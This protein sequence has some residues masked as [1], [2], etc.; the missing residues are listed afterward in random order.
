MAIHRRPQ[1]ARH[2]LPRWLTRLITMALA[3]TLTLGLAAGLQGLQAPL[4]AAPAPGPAARAT[5]LPAEAIVVDMR[6]ANIYGFSTNDKSY[7][8]EGKLWLTYSAQLEQQLRQK[9]IDPI[10]LVSFYNKIKPWDS[11]LISLNQTPEILS[12]GR[13]RSSYTFN[14]NFYADDVDFKL[15][16]FGGLDLS[17]I[18]Q[19]ESTPLST[20]DKQQPIQ[21]IAG[22]GELGSRVNINGYELSGWQF[23]PIQRA[24][25][26]RLEQSRSL[27]PSRLEFQVAYQTSFWA[28]LV[29]WIL[30]LIIV[31][32]LTLFA[33]NI[34]GAM[35][36]ERLAIPPV[37][38]LTIVLMQQSYRDSLPSLPYLTFLDGLYAYSYLVTLAIFVL[39]I[40]SSN[41]LNKAPQDQHA[42]VGRQI[43]RMDTIVQ[44][45][46]LSGYALLVLSWF[47][48][49]RV[50]G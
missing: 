11:E 30:P 32:S 21:L 40:R 15:S 16:P 5:R 1:P 34:C 36:S 9:N 37:V 4:Q 28:A 13:R 50:P 29:E 6:L 48:A 41:L 20:A 3:L 35:G 47:T 43:D 22:E 25:L 18:I 17:V 44:I 45:G 42:A 2:A 31:M 12:D 14:G 10:K 24:R 8:V 33:P 26:S 49:A 27:P 39:F 23:K 38:L 46:A 7:T 19:A